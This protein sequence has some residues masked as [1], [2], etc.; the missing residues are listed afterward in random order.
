L[1]RDRPDQ[2]LRGAV[3]A[4]RLSCRVD[5]TI[6]RRVR[7][8]AVVPDL[9]DQ[10]VLGNDAA[11]LRH[12]VHEQIEDLRLQWDRSAG[13]RQF[14]QVAVQNMI[15]EAKSHVCSSQAKISV[16]SGE[17]QSSAKAWGRPIRQ[18]AAT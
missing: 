15:F 7:N 5:A 4:E 16:V 2:P 1:A 17:N 3:V 14:A 10:V 6:Q 18:G 8:G 13:T 9:A 11:A 12:E